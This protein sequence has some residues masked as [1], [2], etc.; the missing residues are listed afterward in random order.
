MD[1]DVYLSTSA[2]QHRQDGFSVIEL[3]VVVAITVTLTA[4][5]IIGFVGNKRAYAADDE[6]TKI[7]SFFREAH[8]RALAQRQAQRIT[9]DRQNNV[10]RLADMG[11]LPG[12]DEMII[13]RGVLNS[14]VTLEQPSVDG[15]LLSPPTAPY[16]YPA[17]AFDLNGTAE[18]YFLAD[19]SVTNAAGYASP[20]AAPVSLTLFFSPIP[21]T[22]PSASQPAGN[23]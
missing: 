12:G 7:L 4:A 23:P 9:I 3:M 22:A 10:I 19:G 13:T 2:R 18:I 14:Q 8:Q 11:T 20:S 5:T 6:A 17:A 21:G 15:N 1:P 16:N